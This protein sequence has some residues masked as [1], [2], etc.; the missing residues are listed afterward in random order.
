MKMSIA[1]QE[2]QFLD[3]KFKK[4]IQDHLED[5]NSFSEE[6]MN[7]IKKMQED[8]ITNINTMIIANNMNEDMVEKSDDEVTNVDYGFADQTFLEKVIQNPGLQHLAENIFFNLNYK[9]LAA[10]GSVNEAWKK[11]LHDPMFWL[12]KFV[13]RGLSQ[14]NKID[15]IEA[16]QMTRDGRA[17]ADLETNILMYFMRYS[18]NERVMCFDVPCYLNNQTFLKKAPKIIKKF[19][20]GELK[21]YGS[22]EDGDWSVFHDAVLNNQPELIQLLGA[23]TRETNNFTS[24]GRTPIYLAARDGKTEMVKILAPLCIGNDDPNIANELIGYDF[25][26]SEENGITP[27]VEAIRNGN[28]EIVKVLAP[29]ANDEYMLL[30]GFAEAVKRGQT[31]SVKSLAPFLKKPINSIFNYYRN[32]PIHVAAK[33][34][35]VDIVKFLAPLAEYP[36]PANRDGETPIDVAKKMAAKKNSPE[37]SDSDSSDDENLE[38]E[39]E[40]ED[41]NEDESEISPIDVAKKRA[42]KK[43]Y[44]EYSEII[45]ILESFERSATKKWAN[46][47]ELPSE[48]SPKRTFVSVSDSSDDDE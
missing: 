21:T 2:L 35:H 23:L 39:S 11:F 41:E 27:I 17:D 3:E 13:Q 20:E 38:S 47:D 44:P 24:L 31:E 22:D 37:Y 25:P 33:N 5:T 14:K 28:V 15:W 26:N 40:D 18:R 46:S 48:K 36:I 10:C 19:K 43:N 34:G 9:A 29:L 1:K 30:V 6:K 16:I 45:S 32:T 42:A 7:E 4:F 8:L 12:K